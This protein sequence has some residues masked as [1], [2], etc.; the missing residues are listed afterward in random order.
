MRAIMA[1]DDYTC[2]ICSKMIDLEEYYYVYTGRLQQGVESGKSNKEY[3]LCR[4]CFNQTNAE[5]LI[6]IEKQKKKHAPSQLAGDGENK[7]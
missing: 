3:V 4:N 5:L 7:Q 2:Y 6:S 1:I